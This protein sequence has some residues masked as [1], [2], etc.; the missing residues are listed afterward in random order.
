MQTTRIIAVRVGNIVDRVVRHERMFLGFGLLVVVLLAWG[1]LLSGAGT[2]QEMGGMMM[3]MSAWPWT[4][5]HALLMLVM[6]LVMMTAMMLPSAAP[7]ILLFTTLVRRSETG[8]AGSS[9]PSLF[10]LG[11]L[12]IWAAFSLAAVFLQFLLE[13]AA[14][15]SAMM[16]STSMGLSG[17]LLIGAGIYQLTPLKRSCLSLCRSPLEFLASHWR[18]GN[19][20]AFAMGV[21]HGTYCLGC[22]WGLMLLLF[23]GGVMNL[24]WIAGL[25][26]VVF[27]EKLAP[28]G[29]WIGRALG[30]PLIAA[31]T[32]L[33]VTTTGEL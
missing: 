12:S 32:V 23:V 4:V 19:R 15:L 26:I 11:Y 8:R 21:R 10:V 5:G 20:G 27:L 28:G 6:W 24:L 9:A 22:C 7:A 25:A 1:Y 18:T 2:M 17:T 33:L 16:E 31:G 30:V 14:L 29:Q 3:P 13:R